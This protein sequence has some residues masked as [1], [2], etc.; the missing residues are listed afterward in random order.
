[1]AQIRPFCGIYPRAELA[2]QIA[3]LP[4]DVYSRAEAA[5][6]VARQPMSFLKIDRA[7]TLLGDEVD[8]YAPEVYQKARSVL[9][10]MV[11]D[12]SFQKDSSPCY[13]IYELT[14][15]GR[16]QTGLVACSSVDDYVNGVVARHENT[17]SDKEEDRIRHVDV[18]DAQTGPIFLAYRSNDTL[19]ACMEKAKQSEPMFDFI[20]PDGIRHRGFRISDAAQID[21]VTRAFLEIPRT[22]I[23]DG[24]HRAASAVKVS[25]MRREQARQRGETA[26]GEYDSFLSVLFAHDE[27]SILDYN[28]IVA[29]LNGNTVKEFLEKLSKICEIRENQVKEHICEGGVCRMEAVNAPFRPQKKGEMGMY[30]DGTWYALSFREECRPDHPVDGLDVSL[31]QNEA[32]GPI[33][34]IADPKTDQRISF[35][36]GIR[37]LAELKR[38]V[39]AGGGVAFAM[40]P[41][42]MEELLRVADASLLMPPKSTWFE[43]KLRSGLFI[44]ALN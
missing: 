41:T 11:A 34:G 21:A 10:G 39:D 22:Y 30:L 18:C 16:V 35:V 37:G 40:Y 36:G 19:R 4:Y 5:A 43:P 32:L 12:G 3:A 28:R 13:Y 7:E 23:A 6:E 27:L 44:H 8:M 31:L 15:D 33:L 24:H 20:S 29:D 17:R 14:M 1:M 38:R 9:W 42:S 26:G 2:E 25:L